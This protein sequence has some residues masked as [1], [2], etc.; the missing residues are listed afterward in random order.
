MDFVLNDMNP[1]FD[2]ISEQDIRNIHKIVSY[3]YSYLSKD[4]Q[5]T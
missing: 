5:I 4:Y 1:E 3:Q 2:K